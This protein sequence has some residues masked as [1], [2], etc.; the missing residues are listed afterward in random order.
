[1]SS[2]S[3]DGWTTTPPT[4]TVCTQDQK[5]PERT[6]GKK[7]AVPSP[8]Q[9][10]GTALS[11][12]PPAYPGSA[13]SP[14]GRSP[15]SSAQRHR[16]RSADLPTLPSTGWPPP[17]APV[18]RRPS[19]SRVAPVASPWSLEGAWVVSCMAAQ[20]G[21]P[22]HPLLRFSP[23]SGH[24]FAVFAFISSGHRPQRDRALSWDGE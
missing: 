9:L 11:R 13:Q 5:A 18:T 8:Y 17:R 23:H 2:A 21:G 24:G 12:R 16:R 3:W 15:S 22:G 1:M 6:V 19:A 20:P 7:G 14:C 4:L 10:S